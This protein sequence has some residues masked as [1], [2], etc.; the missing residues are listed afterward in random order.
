MSEPRQGAFKFTLSS[1]KVVVL[2]EPLIR[3]QE[4][5]LELAS[6]KAKNETMIGVYAQKELLKMLLISVDGKTLSA[7]EREQLD[8]HF[9]FSEWMQVQKALKKVAG[10]DALGEPEL[11]IV[12]ASGDK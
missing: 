2:R 12:A 4:L 10:D 9:T 3:D 5:A 1:K 7:T 6:A 11:E 8:K